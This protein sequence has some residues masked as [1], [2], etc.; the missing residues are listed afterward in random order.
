MADSIVYLH[1][2]MSTFNCMVGLQLLK[3]MVG[4]QILHTIVGL[5]SLIIRTLIWWGWDLRGTVSVFY[6]PFL[7]RL[8]NPASISSGTEQR[9]DKMNGQYAIKQNNLTEQY[10]PSCVFVGFPLQPTKILTDHGWL[11]H[12]YLVWFIF[13]VEGQ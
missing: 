8:G 2:P 10:E 6:N 13:F 7:S 9:E 3:T 4:P 11:C 1:S 5:F 12:W